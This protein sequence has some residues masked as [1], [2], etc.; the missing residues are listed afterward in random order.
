VRS[1]KPRS[2]LGLFER[3]SNTS[4]KLVVALEL[5]FLQ[6]KRRPLASESEPHALSVNLKTLRS[7]ELVRPDR[8]WP[9]RYHLQ[10]ARPFGSRIG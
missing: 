7:G 1:E 2:R 4:G 10:S 5:P 6:P 9:G 3:L 8:K